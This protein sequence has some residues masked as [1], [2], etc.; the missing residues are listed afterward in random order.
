MSRRRA[1]PALMLAAL[2][3]AAPA[4]DVAQ[5]R[6]R[7]QVPD[8][9]QVRP[10]PEPAPQAAEPATRAAPDGESVP[11]PAAGESTPARDAAAPAAPPPTRAP[12]DA[13]RPL[14]DPETIV[15]RPLAERVLA[16]TPAAAPAAA[17]GRGLADPERRLPGDGPFDP[18]PAPEIDPL[19]VPAPPP[20]AAG[21]EDFLPIPDRWRL[22]DSLGVVEEKWWDPYNQNTLKGDKPI[23]FDDWCVP[24]LDV[25]LGPSPSPC[26]LVVTVISDT[27]I[28]P[29]S[30][31]TPTGVQTTARPGTNDLFG[32]S[33]QFLFNQ[34]LIHGVSFINGN[35][36][37][38]PQDLEFRFT[39]VLN[40][41]FTEVEERRVLNANPFKG[42]SGGTTRHDWHYGVQEAFVDYHLANISDR[43]DFYSIRAGIQPYSTDFRGFLFQDNQLGFRFFGN[44]DDNFWQYNLAWFRRLEKDTNSG[45]NDVT[46]AIRDDDVFI[47]SVFRQDFPVVG[48][49][50]QGTFIYNRNR[51][52]DNG[53][54]FDDNDFLARPA[55]IA[56]ATG[57]D[58]DVFYAGINQD[59]RV[60]RVNLTTSAYYAFGDDDN[61]FTGRGQ[62]IS[63]YF[64]A[65]EASMD[66]DWARIRLSG[67]YASGDGDP[68][69]DKAEG[70]D[71]I[72]ENPQFAGGDTSYW[73]RQQIPLIGG[74]GVGLSSRNAVLPA[75]RHSK[76]HGQSN[77]VNPGITLI[78][79]GADLDL[80]PEF[81]I[82][83]NANYL[84]FNDTSSLEALR[85]Q[86]IDNDIGADL[87]LA[88][89]W[90][91]FQH[92]NVVLR[93]SGAVLLPGEG[94]NDLYADQNDR[95]F[96]YSVLA[97]IVLS[98]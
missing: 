36:A 40:Y 26:F 47:A 98:Y 39:G 28:E 25:I 57:R 68:Y 18:G 44:A 94:F 84:W 52:G 42:G 53:R 38:R 66:F 12:T 11:P 95:D 89:I 80:T 4:Q 16:D 13:E 9:R 50:S 32:Q 20:R 62:D 24:F 31:P 73:I 75:L 65:A 54:Y 23:F 22:A 41:N 48:I 15:R 93:L 63:A 83:G 92:Q 58:Y 27:V 33:Q 90:R 37:F 77:F 86:D 45:L 30:F 55:T 82:S 17:A 87:S 78:G 71:A 64:A 5:L 51:E 70:F 74:G 91:P 81:R 14:A 34:N 76:E 19:A 61:Q 59:G 7:D 79:V 72:F 35:T 43:Y 56:N 10:D 21:A 46:Q 29:R 88:A 2:A 97:N 8:I 85:V 69:D 1:L 60:G 96:H 67:L 49:Q 6:R 3:T